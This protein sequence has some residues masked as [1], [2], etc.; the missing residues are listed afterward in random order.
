MNYWG[1]FFIVC[2]IIMPFVVCYFVG[3]AE[4]EEGI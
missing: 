1:L 3:K 4:Q 2:T